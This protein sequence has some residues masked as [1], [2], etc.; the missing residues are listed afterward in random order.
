MRTFLVLLAL[1]W[2]VS[3]GAADWTVWPTGTHAAIRAFETFGGDESYAAGDSGYLAKASGNG[4]SW[5]TRINLSAERFTALYEPAYGQVWASGADGTVF[6]LF[7]GVWYTRG[8]S[9]TGQYG[10]FT[11]D[12]QAEDAVGP[13]GV[14]LR[15]TD[16]GV[17]WVSLPS[18]TNQALH[19]G[20]GYVSYSSVVV[21][22]NGA[23]VLSTNGGNRW[24]SIPAPT[25]ESLNSVRFD[26]TQNVIVAVGTNGVI[27][28]STNT[29]ASWTQVD[30]Y[31]SANLNSVSG[32]GNLFMA[33][34]DQGTMV[35]STDWGATRCVLPSPTSGNLY[36]V[37]VLAFNNYFVTG[38]N[39]LLMETTDG[40]G[41]CLDPASVPGDDAAAAYGIRL[42][43]PQPL[44]AGRPGSLTLTVRDPQRVRMDLFDVRGRRQSGLLDDRLSGG[45]PR[46]VTIDPSS[47]APGIYLLRISGET[48][49]TSRK[50]VVAGD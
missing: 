26:Q 18:G 46:T 11:L 27:F 13:G 6:L 2:A 35:K 16:G 21:G 14:I 9:G 33:V 17:H 31:V 15:T 29:G 38:A 50:V 44:L 24:T 41:S 45:Q 39:G 4:T 48:F 34:G 12:S 32:Y 8:F 43:G 36:F 28:R 7:G 49:H 40:G 47:L 22:D 10:Y 25:S 5:T 37:S 20:S 30:S 1:T 23:A 19:G 42:N 3:A